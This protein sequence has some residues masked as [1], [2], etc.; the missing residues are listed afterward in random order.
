MFCR[1]EGNAM[2][3]NNQTETIKSSS[4]SNISANNKQ[5]SGSMFK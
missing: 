2:R 5:S 4:T 1:I 3:I